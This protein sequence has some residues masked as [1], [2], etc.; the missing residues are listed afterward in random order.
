MKLKLGFL[1]T[2][3]YP[4]GSYVASVAFN[5]EFGNENQPPRPFFRSMIANTNVTQM[6]INLL[7]HNSPEKALALLGEELKGKLQQSINDLMEPHLAQSTIDAKG[8][9][10]PLIDTSHMINSV[11]YEVTK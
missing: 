1:D 7:R 9:S 2:A 8:F 6:L 5:N 3:T 10:K 4:D 11:G